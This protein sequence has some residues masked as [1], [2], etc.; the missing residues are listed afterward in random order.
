MAGTWLDGVE[1][2]IECP[3]RATCAG[4]ASVPVPRPGF[5]AGP[6]G[7]YVACPPALGLPGVVHVCAWM[8]RSWH[9]KYAISLLLPT[10]ALVLVVVGVVVVKLLG[11][12]FSLFAALEGVPIT[13]ALDAV[14]ISIAPLAYLPLARTTFT[15]FDCTRLAN[16]DTVIDSDPGVP[17]FD[18]SWWSLFPLGAGFLVFFVLGVPAYFALRLF[19]ARSSLF[20]METTAPIGS[21]Y[22]LYRRAYYWGEV[23]AL[24]KRL[25]L[26]VAGVFFTRHQLVHIGLISSTLIVW[27]VAV[28][29][30]QPFYITMYIHTPARYPGLE[31]G[32]EFGKFGRFVAN[33]NT[34][35]SKVLLVRVEDLVEL[36]ACGIVTDSR[37]VKTPGPIGVVQD[38]VEVEHCLNPL[39]P[40][41]KPT[42]GVGKE[43]GKHHG[44]GRAILEDGSPGQALV[45]GVSGRSSVVALGVG[46]GEGGHGVRAELVVVPDHN[47]GEPGLNDVLRAEMMRTR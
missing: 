10:L 19:L 12:R 42:L 7:N 45:K 25:I 34:D 4:G 8:L 43:V 15:L 11:T 28:V 18:S 2:C 26:V 46:C 33:H 20:E 5:T 29:K 17:C 31:I 21:L 22:R 16:G 32:P 23:A 40:T 14:I 39:V 30:V 27:M 1:G 3:E 44:V 9:L 35:E 6:D 38:V 41:V 24:L 37:Q 47:L 36:V 13:V